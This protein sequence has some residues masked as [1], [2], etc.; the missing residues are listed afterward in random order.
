MGSTKS[1]SYFMISQ[2]K[3]Q[4]FPNSDFSCS[5][6]FL[7]SFLCSLLLY[8]Y[9]SDTN[10]VSTLHELVY[11]IL[12]E[13]VLI[14]YDPTLLFSPWKLWFALPTDYHSSDVV[15]IGDFGILVRSG[16]SVSKALFFNFLSALMAL[17]GTALVSIMEERRA[18]YSPPLLYVPRAKN[19]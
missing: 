2:N 12:N 13:G 11:A 6:S 3:F 5:F 15:Q 1:I 8:Y 4:F 17:A 18:C 7:T 9:Y 10:V 16:F 19:A 14:F